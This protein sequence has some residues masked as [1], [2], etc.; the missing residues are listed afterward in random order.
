MTF[1]PKKLNQKPRLLDCFCGLGGVS[2]GFA[3]EGFDVLGVDIEDMP[4]KG[5]KHKFLR[6]DIRDLRGEDFRGYDVVWGSPP[7]RDFSFLAKWYGKRWK[8]PPD[9]ERGLKTVRTFLKFVEEAQPKF[10]ILENT[11]M[12]KNYLKEIEPRIEAYITRGKRHVFYGNFPLFLLPRDMR[13][14]VRTKSKYGRD[15]PKGDRKISSWLA[16]KIPKPISRAFAQACREAL[17]EK[18]FLEARVE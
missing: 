5:Y 15:C 2:D 18:Q 4:S 17:Q 1:L 13:V 12:L 3:L 8:I 14:T 9:P 7:C 11:F 10:W 16:A 6:A